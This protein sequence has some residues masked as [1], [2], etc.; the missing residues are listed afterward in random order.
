MNQWLDVIVYHNTLRDYLLTAAIIIVLFLVL[1]FFRK[2]V[3]RRM[4]RMA[5]RTESTL[6]DFIIEHVERL[7]LPVLYSAAVYSALQYLTITGTF[8]SVIQSLFVAVLTVYSARFIIAILRYLMENRWMKHLPES[9]RNSVKGISGA[10]SILVW[11]LST[12]FLLD[13]LGFKVSTIVAGLGIG[14]IAVALA[15]QTILGDLFSYFVIF[16]DRPFQSGDFIIVDDKIGAVEY[17]GIKTTRIRSLSG[18]ELVFS[19]KDLTDSRI[20]NFKKMG[21]RRV[22]FTL[23]VTYETSSAQLKEI[24]A[25]IKAIIESHNDVTFD[26]AHFKEYGPSSLNFEIVYYVIGADYNRYMDI[27][28]SINLKIFDEFEKRRISFAYPTQTLY[29]TKQN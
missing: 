17:I 28:Q 20:H 26:R 18:E 19:N 29:L 12:V 10:L 16:F 2:I 15:A 3:I 25:L 4:K 24:P 5:E 27:Q 8:S 21:R 7:G 9:G 14:G 1:S 13:N 11:G 6:D 23:G 22:V